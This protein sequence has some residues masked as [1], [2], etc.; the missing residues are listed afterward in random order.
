MWTHI[1]LNE[2][3]I[4]I[5]PPLAGINTLRCYSIQRSLDQVFFNWLLNFVQSYILGSSLVYTGT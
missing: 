3:P 4:P 5:I 1:V 2:I